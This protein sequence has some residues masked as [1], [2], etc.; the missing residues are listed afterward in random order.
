MVHQVAFLLSLYIKYIICT[1]NS[2]VVAKSLVHSMY[3]H[4]TVWGHFAQE[5]W[6]EHSANCIQ[7]S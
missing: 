2:K 5:I 1:S 7:N 6:S 4:L 3:V